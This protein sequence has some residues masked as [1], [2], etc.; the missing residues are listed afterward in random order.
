MSFQILKFDQIYLDKLK[1]IKEDNKITLKNKINS[2]LE[3]VYFLTSATEY[4][5]QVKYDRLRISMTYGGESREVKFFN[6]VDE[7]VPKIVYANREKWFPEDFHCL[8]FEEYKENYHKIVLVADE[9]VDAQTDSVQV[10]DVFKIAAS[11]ETVAEQTIKYKI[12]FPVSTDNMGELTIPIYDSNKNLLGTGD[13]SHIDPFQELAFSNRKIGS[14]VRLN[15]IWIK[16]EAYG[17]N[18]NIVQIKLSA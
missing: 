9:I 10:M 2:K 14:L 6:R 11:A 13:F 7:Y 12:W 5:M 1:Y 15:S 17:V 18:M 3:D 8:S 4:K 16:E